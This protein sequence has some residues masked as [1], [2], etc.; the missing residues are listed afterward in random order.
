[1]KHPGSLDASPEP[2]KAGE[3]AKQS[4]M[5]MQWKAYGTVGGVAGEPMSRDREEA[6]RR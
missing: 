5:G 6:S 2:F 1:M 4:A 3:D